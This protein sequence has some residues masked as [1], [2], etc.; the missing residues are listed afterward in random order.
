LAPPSDAL[1][2]AITAYTTL[3]TKNGGDVYVG[4]KLGLYLSEAGFSSV[5]VS[6]RYECYPS[7][8][9]IGE[10]LALQL[11]QSGYAQLSA[12]LIEWSKN[13]SG[14]FAQAWISAIGKR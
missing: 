6:A 2:E 10:Y 14:L 4:R 11:K 13:S 1:T 8:S 7:L 3:Q 12:A 9:F 5:Q